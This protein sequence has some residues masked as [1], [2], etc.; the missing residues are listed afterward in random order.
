M[1]RFIRNLEKNREKILAGGVKVTLHNIQK[2][3]GKIFTSDKTLPMLW[4]EVS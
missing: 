1:Q 4:D 3:H 2:N